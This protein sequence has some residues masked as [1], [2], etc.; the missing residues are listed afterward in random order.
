MVAK[1]IPD[2]IENSNMISQA[3]GYQFFLLHR[4]VE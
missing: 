1:K 2:L 4:T 3:A